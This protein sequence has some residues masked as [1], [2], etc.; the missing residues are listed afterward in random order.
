MEG[1]NRRRDGGREGENLA[2]AREVNESQEE[3]DGRVLVLCGGNKA[4]R[5]REA[6]GR[7]EE[8]SRYEGGFA[9]PV[10]LEEAEAPEHKQPCRHGRFARHVLQL[11]GGKRRSAFC[12]LR[13]CLGGVRLSY[14]SFGVRGEVF[15]VEY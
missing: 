8:E 5:G 7:G 1:G 2:G 3:A 13:W 9:V 11:R 14:R 12:V 6:S 10:L 15:S 4:D